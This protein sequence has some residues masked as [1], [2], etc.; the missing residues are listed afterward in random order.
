MV[1]AGL[2]RRRVVEISDSSSLLSC[3]RVVYSGKRRCFRGTLKT[4]IEFG[5][6]VKSG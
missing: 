4:V 6:T 1:I 5:G 3:H 2:S